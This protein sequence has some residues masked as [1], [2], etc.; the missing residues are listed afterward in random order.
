MNILDK[1][2]K[3][4]V[5]KDGWILKERTVTFKEGESVFDILKRV[6]KDNKIHMEASFTPLYNSTYI[7]GIYNLYEFDCGSLSGWMYSVNGEFPNYGCSKYIVK[8]GDV[9]RWQYTCDLGKDI[10]GGMN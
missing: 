7:E 4:I 1:D 8:K 9:I 6:C 3:D 2:K 5:P 10:G